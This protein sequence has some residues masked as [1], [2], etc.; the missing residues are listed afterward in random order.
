MVRCW[1]RLLISGLCCVEAHPLKPTRT[2][3]VIKQSRLMWL[4]GA[5]AVTHHRN[6]GGLGEGLRGRG[7]F[8]D[9]GFCCVVRGL[10]NEAGQFR[11]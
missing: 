2:N 7:F 11:N 8:K 6:S 3:P 5:G 10:L 9:L 4:A 1:G